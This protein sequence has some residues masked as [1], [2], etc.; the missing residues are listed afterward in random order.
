[1]CASKDNVRHAFNRDV[2]MGSKE[3]VEFIFF[4]FFFIIYLLKELHNTGYLKQYLKHFSSM[5][6]FFLN[7]NKITLSHPP[8]TPLD[9]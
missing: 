7:T 9:S 2:G 8:H 1:M 6:S 4:N 3:L 5:F